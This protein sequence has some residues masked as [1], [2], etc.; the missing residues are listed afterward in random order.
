MAVVLRNIPKGH[1]WGW[2]SRE[3]PRMHLQT[4]DEEH[5]NLYKVWLEEKGARAFQPAAAIPAKVLKALQAEFERRRASVEAKWVNLMI[6]QG[7]L[8][9]AVQGGII[10]LTAY[11]RTSRFE[12]TIELDQHLAPAFAGRVR[13]RDV[14]LNEEFAVV[15]I[16]PDKPEAD[17]Y[18]IDIPPILWKTV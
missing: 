11:P 4:V 3:D 15:E 14:R 10:V 17:R 6:K 8:T 2:F 12:R 13:P 7:W 18:W 1:D 5:R 9:L 16:W